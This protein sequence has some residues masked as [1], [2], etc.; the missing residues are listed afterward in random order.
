MLNWHAEDRGLAITSMTVD[1]APRVGRTSVVSATIK[2]VSRAEETN[3][4]VQATA[5]L[6]PIG[7]TQTIASLPG[8]TTTT[9][10]FNWVPSSPITYNVIVKVDP[11]AAEPYTVD[12]TR[13]LVVT[14]QP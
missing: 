3:L 10:S 2:N 9:V 11:I 8:L 7:T 13:K 14:A 12:N 6:A 1:P 4:R 5:N